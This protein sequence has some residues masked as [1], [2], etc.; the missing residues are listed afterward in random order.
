MQV[1]VYGFYNHKNL[2]DDFFIEAFHKIFHEYQF[3]FTDHLTVNDIVKSDAVFFG[4]GSFLDQPISGYNIETVPLLKTRPLCYIGVGVETDIH[5][6]HKELIRWARFVATRT[7]NHIQKLQTLNPNTLSIPDL[8]YALA[9]KLSINKTPNSILVLPNISVVPTHNDPH[10]MHSAWQHFKTEFAQSLDDAI[11]NG[12]T[13]HFL[14]FC[15][16]PKLNDICIVHEIV[17]HM[18]H[19]NTNF[20][21]TDQPTSFAATTELVSQFSAVI[22]A[23]YHGSIVADMCGVPYLT[24]HHHDKLKTSSSISYYEVSKDKLAKELQCIKDSECRPTRIE[25]NIYKEL[26]RRVQDAVCGS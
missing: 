6:Q 24:I 10:W 21:L 18:K 3:N 15:T 23:R 2:G 8:V 25:W 17:A 7:P 13:I 4:G 14:P 16:D 19:R 22:S 9:P 1:L 12:R 11:D 20:I 26:N 5:H